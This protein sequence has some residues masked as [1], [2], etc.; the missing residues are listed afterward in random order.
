[1]LAIGTMAEPEMLKSLRSIWMTNFGADKR[2]PTA[3]IDALLEAIAQTGSLTV[4]EIL[5]RYA[6]AE[7]TARIYLARTLVYL[8]KFG[9]L[10]RLPQP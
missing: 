10:R 8:L 1:M 2:S 9:V 4:A 6:G 7:P 5:H 3:T